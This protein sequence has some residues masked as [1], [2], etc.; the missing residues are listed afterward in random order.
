[1]EK[2]L[3]HGSYNTHTHTHTQTRT[4]TRAHKSTHTHTHTYAQ[5]Q[6]CTQKHTNLRQRQRLQVRDRKWDFTSSLPSDSSLYACGQRTH[7]SKEYTP[8][9][10]ISQVCSPELQHSQGGIPKESGR[11]QIRRHRIIMEILFIHHIPIF[12]LSKLRV[13]TV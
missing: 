7:N 9:A 1:M 4:H 10:R 5:T 13:V 12:K 8:R 6:K 11:R 3:L 2:H